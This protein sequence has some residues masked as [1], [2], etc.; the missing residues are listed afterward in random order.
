MERKEQVYEALNGFL[1]NKEDYII[2]GVEIK[3]E[4]EDG[5][6]LT[7]SG[8]RIYTAKANLQSL[9]SNDAFQNVETITSQYEKMMR[10]IAYIMFEYGLV[11]GKNYNADGETI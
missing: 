3:N 7:K 1:L 6:E 4:F 2:D 5:S 11:F 9:L 8:D 10:E